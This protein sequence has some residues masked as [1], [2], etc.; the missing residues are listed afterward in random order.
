MFYFVILPCTFLINEEEWKIL[1]L[2]NY[3]Y[4]Q[5]IKMFDCCLSDRLK[6]FETPKKDVIEDNNPQNEAVPNND[7]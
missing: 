2:D 7:G 5:F 6:P 1:M 4:A 3:W